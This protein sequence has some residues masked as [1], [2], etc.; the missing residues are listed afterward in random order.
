MAS[1]EGEAHCHNVRWLADV[2]ENSGAVAGPP[3]VTYRY[4][5]AIFCD[6]LRREESGKLI[7]VGMY[8]SSMVVSQAPS[9]LPSLTVFV[10]SKTPVD[11]PFEK[12]IVRILLDD[13][14]IHEA[15]M[16]IEKPSLG[17]LEARAASVPGQVHMVHSIATLTPFPILKSG[18]LRVR[19]ETEA[20]V[21]RAGALRI[22]VQQ[23]DAESESADPGKQKTQ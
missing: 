20:E 12:F 6:D 8:G 9:L 11:N 2:G 7:V 19:V 13:T 16:T 15:A 5:D 21:L 14:L 23:S 18:V 3:E 10:R 17:E 1:K 4:A 22:E